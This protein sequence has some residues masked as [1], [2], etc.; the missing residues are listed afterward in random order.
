MQI[1]R[2]KTFDKI[3]VHYFIRAQILRLSNQA[4]PIKGIHSSKVIF[5]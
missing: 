5:Y 3:A 1:S 2:E 4:K